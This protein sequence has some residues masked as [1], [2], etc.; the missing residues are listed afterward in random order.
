MR[1]KTRQSARRRQ[2]GVA[3]LLALGVLSL[4]MVS[5]LAFVSNSMLARKSAAN[6][7]GRAQA[8]M[9]ASS[10]INRIMLQLKY[11]MHEGQSTHFGN[12]VSKNITAD[13]S[14]NPTLDAPLA[15]MVDGVNAT[16]GDSKWFF[17]YDIY[18]NGEIVTGKSNDAENSRI[19]GRAAYSAVPAAA[20][21]RP[22]ASSSRACVPMCWSVWTS[23]CPAICWLGRMTVSLLLRATSAVMR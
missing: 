17:L 5:G 14:N 18:D 20:K 1:N 7:R 13:G 8:K 10:T 15:G 16:G 3:L 19:I 22:C 2:R 4:L 6:F 9:I 11:Y 23:S 12:L 21:A